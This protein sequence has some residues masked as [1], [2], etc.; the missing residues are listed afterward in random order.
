MDPTQHNAGVDGQR[1]SSAGPILARLRT[2]WLRDCLTMI[3]DFLPHVD[4]L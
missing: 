3:L 1:W 2:Q 4:I